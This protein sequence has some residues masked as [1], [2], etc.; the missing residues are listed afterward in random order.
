MNRF[1]TISEV[2]SLTTLSRA[3]IYRL[4][5]QGRFPEQ[6]VLSGNRI[7]WAEH[8]VQAWLRGRAVR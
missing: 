2:V 7:G 8:E 4:V 1:L 5:A 3:T 6:K